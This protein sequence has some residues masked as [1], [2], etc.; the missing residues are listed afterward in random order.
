MLHVISP[1]RL[2][3]KIYLNKIPGI[4]SENQI[5]P[6]LGTTKEDTRVSPL[7]FALPPT[8]A[9]GNR[10]EPLYHTSPRVPP[11]VLVY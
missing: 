9:L 10:G 8:R 11:Y 6:E 3:L 2:Y 1:L 5:S 7:V 4:F